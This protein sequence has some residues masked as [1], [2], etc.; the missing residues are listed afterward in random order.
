[1]DFDALAAIY[2]AKNDDE[3]IQ[4][5]EQRGE[6]TS[7]AQM[8][9][10]AEL[11]LRKIVIPL[12][13]ETLTHHS[14]ASYPRAIAKPQAIHVGEFIEETLHFYIGNRWLFL[15]LISPAVLIGYFSIVFARHETRA[16]IHKLYPD[17]G[18][19][20]L[21][22]A[23]LKI[24]LVSWAGYLVSWMA[25]SVSFAAICYAVKQRD[26][27]FDISVQDSF[28]IVSRRFGAFLRLSGLLLFVVVGLELFATVPVT[29]LVDRFFGYRY[30]SQ[31]SICIYL[32]VGAALLVASRFGLAIP[33]FVLDEYSAARAMF[34]SDEL[35]RGRWAILAALLFKSGVG[36]YVAGMLPFWLAQL[37]LRG[38][39]L[40]AWS[41]QVLT[42]I[43]L[44]AVIA[45]EPVMFI[46]FALLYLRAS[47]MASELNAQPVLA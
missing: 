47:A 38:V 23:V 45:V 34:R 11:A 36:G 40:P 4:L 27:G 46:G 19:H 33:A 3:L 12:A 6:L 25:F 42:G 29:F 28:L 30:W 2:R 13:A 5:F 7:E 17:I 35:T 32:L 26:E 18:P 31:L 37:L 16:L 9:L 24:G 20:A 15:R 1:M 22:V 21:S 10:S 14:E 41:N 39:H 44:A 43:S 8:A